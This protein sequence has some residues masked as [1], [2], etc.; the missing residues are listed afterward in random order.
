MNKF[1]KRLAVF[2]LV[3]FLIDK[4]FIPVRNAAPSLEV[5]RRLE[6][7][8][9]G[10]I[11]AELIILGSS[12][13]ARCFIAEQITQSTD[14]LSM[15]LSYPGSNVVFHEFLLRQITEIAGNTMPRTVVLVVDD[16]DELS[17]APSL[18]FRLDR[19]YPLVKYRPIRDEMVK[20]DEKIPF[21]NEF[22]VLHQINKSN[23]W[24]HQK[25]FSQNDVI[26]PCGSMP[27]PHQKNSFNK[28][29]RSEETIYDQSGELPEKMMAFK[30]IV[31]RCRDH[32]IQLIVVIPPNF[33]KTTHG[34]QERLE[35]LVGDS[36]IVWMYDDSRP[37]YKN[38][39]FF[40]DHAHLRTSG[41]ELFTKE[42][43]EYYRT[44]KVRR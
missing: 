25:K 38:E 26:M 19:L 18:T 14:T 8:V 21:V 42:F 2:A 4:I 41:A 29:F 35:E 27:I 7:I 39:Q 28:Q 36:G 22:L 13:G 6:W 17:T 12:R 20:R 23:L 31:A 43:I 10:K 24:L 33:K 37:E 32:K 9:T 5:D 30:Q 16:S 44:I 11:D 3:F 1:I 40:F 34:F 15:N